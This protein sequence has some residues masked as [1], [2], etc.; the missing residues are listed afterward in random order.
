MTGEGTPPDD[1]LDQYLATLAVKG[2]SVATQR[3]T[4]SDL[5][6]FCSWWETKHQRSFDLTQVIDRD[7]REW[8]LTRQKIDGAAPATIN[9]GLSTLR[10]LCAWAIEQK[11]LA[12][13]PT[14]GIEDVPATLLSPRSLPD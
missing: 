8:K 7:L 6:L 3:A 5:T 14:K 10:R 12:D 9:R 4:R 2:V 13:N 11:L 1:P